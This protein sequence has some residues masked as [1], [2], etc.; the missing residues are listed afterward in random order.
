MR[1]LTQSLSLTSVA[2]A[3]R[4]VGLWTPSEI[5]AALWLD[6]AD[7]GT[8]TQSGG[9]VSQWSDKSGGGY[10]AVQAAGALQPQ[11]GVAQINDKNAIRFTLDTLAT[12]LVMSGSE[13]EV[14]AVVSLNDFFNQTYG[15]IISAAFEG[16]VDFNNDLSWAPIL[17]IGDSAAVGA[18]ANGTEVLPTFSSPAGEPHIL[19]GSLIGNQPQFTFD[20]SNTG[21]VATTLALNA[22]GGVHIGGGKVE[23]IGKGGFDVSEIIIAQNITNT[24]KKRIEGYLA[25]KW[26][27]VANLPADHPYKTVAP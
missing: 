6:A 14:F 26:G 7:A 27:L 25:W 11:T 24:D 16:A 12:S 15:R 18:Y 3:V 23:S 19:N 8:I 10:H 9:L 21:T 22:T 20:A 4:S 5:S 17:R 2:T 13:W 1:N